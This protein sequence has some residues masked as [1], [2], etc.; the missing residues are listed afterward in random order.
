MAYEPTTTRSVARLLPICA[1]LS[2]LKLATSNGEIAIFIRATFSA[3]IRRNCPPAD[4]W[5][6]SQSDRAVESHAR[7]ERSDRFLN[8]ST[9]TERRGVGGAI[10]LPIAVAEPGRK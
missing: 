1:R 6:V 4:S 3:G 9:A 5:V 10:S 7:S 8:P 2:R